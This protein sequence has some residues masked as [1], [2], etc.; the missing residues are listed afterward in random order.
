[1][2]KTSL[3]LY[4]M[5]LVTGLLMS[6][7][8]AA[9]NAGNNQSRFEKNLSPKSVDIFDQPGNAVR[10][11]K[12]SYSEPNKMEMDNS[13]VET[14]YDNY[15]NKTEN[16]VFNHDPLVKMIVLRTTVDGQ[17]Q[18]MIY[19]Q[20]GDIKMAP[21]KILENILRSPAG[22]IAKAVEI[23]EGRNAIEKPLLLPKTQTNTNENPILKTPNVQLSVI[24]QPTEEKPETEPKNIPSKEFSAPKKEFSDSNKGEKSS[25]VLRNLLNQSTLKEQADVWKNTSIIFCKK[26]LS[27]FELQYLIYSNV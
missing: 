1:M 14:M 4:L 25:G 11:T 27:N 18:A 23:T 3:C 20:N 5:S 17:A 26:S 10:T 9:T 21:P 22:E 13:V 6:C 15:G 7:N 12:A 16:R 8:N 2:K 19:A 24:E